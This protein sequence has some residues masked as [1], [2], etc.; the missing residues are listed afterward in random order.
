MMVLPEIKFK[1]N[2][3]LRYNLYNKVDCIIVG[4]NATKN[5]INNFIREKK[6]YT[7]KLPEVGEKIICLVNN[8]EILSTHSEKFGVLPLVNGTIGIVD[9]IKNDEAD[10]CFYCTF[11]LVDD[12]SCKFENI[13]ID[14][15]NFDPNI[16]MRPSIRNTNKSEKSDFYNE[17]SFAYA[18]TC[19]KSQGS[20]FNNILVIAERMYID[21]N[22]E[23]SY[24]EFQSKWLYTAV[25]RAIKKCILVYNDKYYDGY[26]MK[27]IEKSNIYYKNVD[28]Y[29]PIEE[30]DFC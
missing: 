4:K 23:I 7:N 11:H 15:Y 14:Y 25:T 26:A 8:Y 28:K 3:D 1:D 18:I 16:K 29:Y 12:M 5:K 21:K 22:N 17:F 6:G 27:A 30:D 2:E 13:K 24:E 10:K 19:H 9:S 20:Q